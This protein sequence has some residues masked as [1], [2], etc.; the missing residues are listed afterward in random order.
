MPTT[1]DRQAALLEAALA[2]A[3]LGWPVLPVTPKGKL[4]LTEHGLHDATI[5]RSKIEAWWSRWPGANVGIALA[6]A[7]LVAVD[8]DPRNGGTIDA[9]PGPVD[10]LTARTGGG[11]W[12]LLFR[13]PE[14]AKLPGTLGPGIDIKHAGYIVAE[15]SVHPSGTTYQWLDWEVGDELPAIADAPAWLLCPQKATAGAQAGSHAG[16]RTSA[17][18]RNERLSRE[19]FR[20]RKLGLD[21][22]AILVALRGLNDALCDPP[23]EA[24]EVAAIARGKEG[25]EPDDGQSAGSPGG[26]PG[27]GG[28]WGIAADGTTPFR[29]DDFVHV[30]PAGK[31]AFMPAR[32]LW[33]APGVDRRVIPWPIGADGE[34]VPPSSWIAMHRPVEQLTWHPDEPEIIE[35]RLIDAGGWIDRSGAH[36][37][38]L[39]RPPRTIEGDPSKAGAWRDHLRCIYP[40]EAEHIERW[41][42][43]RIQRPGQ[44][45]NHAIVLGGPQG[46][47]KDTLVEPVKHGVGPWNWQD[48]SPTQM[49]G[50]FNGWA[51]AVVVRVSEAR[52]LGDVDRFALYDHSKTYIAAPPDVIRVD[53][54]NL[55]EHPV[56]NVMGVVIT[57]NHR[58]DGIYLP[59]DD[60]RHFVAWSE[61]TKDD[62]T[63]RYWTDLWKWYE[64][65]GIA[66][67]VAYLRALDL[68]EFDPKAPPPKTDAFWAIVQAGQDPESGELHDVIERAGNPDVLTFDAIAEHANAL[69]MY[70]LASLFRDRKSARTAVHKLER[71]GYTSIRNP[72]TDT[73][74]WRVGGQRKTVFARA[75]LS[76]AGR[77]SAARNLARQ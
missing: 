13:A 51:K 71:A 12:H 56:F 54:K 2:Y 34:A 30:V 45:V 41:L 63:P 39:Y 58:T 28:A 16:G 21:V 25:V 72:D 19:A 18:G 46:I 65:G 42:A 57:T 69:S 73:G 53:E 67:V 52:D 76:V 7:G 59:A 61:A 74:L 62:F 3:A 55:R 70:D 75:S 68:T 77:I 8:I 29:L 33:S 1:I 23:L 10:T 15:P 32:D 4:P 31:F 60:R 48:I 5:D 37:L 36:V 24:D 20:L 26:E 35:G 11:G 40:G 47:G 66:H 43:H 6:P 27:G 14:G 38:N 64:S 44:K 49:M 9:L 50:R 22:D 17:G